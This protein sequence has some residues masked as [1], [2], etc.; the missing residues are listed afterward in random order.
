MV[1]LICEEDE[2]EGRGQRFVLHARDE[3]LER[4][5]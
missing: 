2:L 5:L 3:R 1:K 4:L